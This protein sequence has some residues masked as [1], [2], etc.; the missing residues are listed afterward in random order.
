MANRNYVS[1]GKIYSM[2]VKPVII[3]VKIRIGAAGA[4]TSFQ[5]AMVKSVVRVSQGVYKIKMQDKT[6]YNRIF[7][8]HGAMQSPVTGLSGIVA[9]EIQ[10]APSA[11]MALTAAGELTVKTLSDAITLADPA[12]GSTIN[13]L[14]IASDSGVLL[15][16]E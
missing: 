15:P 11:S 13:L 7:T 14:V 4:V 9:V 10:N 8:T 1:G 5:G 2:H 3:D 12:S 6:S 16:G